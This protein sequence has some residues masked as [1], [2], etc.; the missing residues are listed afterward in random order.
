MDNINSNSLSLLIPKLYSFFANNMEILDKLDDAMTTNS[1]SININIEDSKGVI[2]SVTIPSFKWMKNNI[3]RLDKNLKTLTNYGGTGRSTIQLEDGTYRRVMLQNFPSEAKNIDALSTVSG[4]NVKSNWFFESLINPLMYVSFNLKNKVDETTDKVM[5]KRFILKINDND[6][7]VDWFEQN[8]LNS[9]NID[10][11]SFL[12]SIVRNDI[13]YVLD[14]DIVNLPPVEK[15]YDGQFYIT[16]I[17]NETYMDESKRNKVRKIYTLNKVTYNDVT[18]AFNNS[19]T[20]NTGDSLELVDADGNC[21]TRFT[22]D[23]INTS[24]QQVV[25]KLQEGSGSIS[26]G[27]VL[28][29]A[30][31]QTLN[32]K[33]SDI[34]LDINV[35][36]NEYNVVFVKPID[37]VSNIAATSW[38]KGT[39]F[40]TSKLTTVVNGNT[41]TLEDYYKKYAIDYGQMILDKMKDYFPTSMEG[42]TP[43][44]PILDERNFSIVHINKHLTESAEYQTILT[45]EANKETVKASIANKDTE[46]AL[47]RKEYNTTRD[48]G[49][50]NAITEVLN[51]L[52]NERNQLVA[53]YNGY[54][55][56]I[57]GIV[58]DY[59]LENVK[60]KYKLYGFWDMPE[61]M[62]GVSTGIQNII[63]FK[64]RYRYLSIDGNA[65]DTTTLTLYSNDGT[66]SS[67]VVSNWNYVETAVRRRSINPLTGEYEWDE[68]VTTD[69]DD[70]PINTIGLSI[71]K[72]E[73]IEIQVKSISE[74]GWPSN[75]LESEWSLPITVNYDPSME[76]ESL[77][78][79][80]ER[81]NV[82]MARVAL[83]RDL[84]S[85]RMYDHLSDSFVNG[86]N[87]FAHDAHSIASGFFSEENSGAP[88][89]LFTKLN[90]V[91]KDIDELKSEVFKTIGELAATLT[92]ERGE[93]VMD[94]TPNQNNLVDCGYYTD[95]A[96]TTEA[97]EIITKKFFINIRSSVDGTGLR[98]IS[99]LHGGRSI[100]ANE[101][102][103]SGC[104]DNVKESFSNYGS[105]NVSDSNYNTRLKYDH[106]P[107]VVNSPTDTK[108][109]THTSRPPMQSAQSCG[110]FVYARY[111]DIDG[112][113]LYTN[114][115]VN[116]NII[117]LENGFSING[118][119]FALRWG[120][121]LP[122]EAQNTNENSE[123]IISVFDDIL[124]DG[125]I[126]Y[127][128]VLKSDL[129]NSADS[130]RKNTCSFY[131]SSMNPVVKDL[132]TLISN[133][134]SMFNVTVRGIKTSPTGNNNVIMFN[135]D[136]SIKGYATSNA[137]NFD[138]TS[139][140]T[141][142]F[143]LYNLFTQ[144][145]SAL[146]EP[147]KMYSSVDANVMPFTA[148]MLPNISR[149][150]RVINQHDWRP[151][152]SYAPVSI[153]KPTKVMKEYVCVK[154]LYNTNTSLRQLGGSEFCIDPDAIVTLY[155]LSPYG[156]NYH[157]VYPYQYT[158]RYV[159]EHAQEFNGNFRIGVGAGNAVGIAND[160]LNVP[161][162]ELKNT[163]SIKYVEVDTEYGMD[164]IF[165][166]V[167]CSFTDNDKYNIG[168]CTCGS[169][170][171]LAPQERKDINLDSD[172]IS[173]Y[174]QIWYG[175][176]ESIK[177]PIVFQ[178]RMTDYLGNL[179]G[180][181]Q[182]QSNITE[183]PTYKRK[184]GIDF[185]L[186]D[187]DS[188]KYDLEFFA[189]YKPNG[190]NASNVPRLNI[191]EAMRDIS[192]SLRL[193]RK[194]KLTNISSE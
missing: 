46:I 189:K 71:N 140:Y 31:Y 120:S 190:T 102:S 50:R 79:I 150:N 3:E 90:N 36:F 186:S 137:Q 80:V 132:P 147:R 26:R 5:V 76:G 38:S 32:T 25:L 174:K 155:I 7:K 74:A 94:L 27:S 152:T 97:G 165:R 43:N 163:V 178:Y 128:W 53:E 171:Y 54:V 14:E 33:K 83:M 30:T 52:T 158:A 24:K 110:Q 21:S 98:L 117:T 169:Y 67:A 22:I 143:V 160:T 65:N 183:N 112:A 15:R 58:K 162:Y 68:V 166:T 156:Q 73:Q 181:K 106:V 75:P 154:N 81:N 182:L 82:D 35:G 84:E 16:D 175:D 176:K 119:E 127:R 47:R 125:T 124:Q 8:L 37:P 72:G 28:R 92:N 104:Y 89:T 85:L 144:A 11:M 194:T 193:N 129:D 118:S 107:I 57:Q 116:D 114:P 1:D 56:S 49:T 146:Y 12:T 6:T 141:K 170:L 133:F 172:D 184:I 108:R 17:I 167:R 9:D 113:P 148:G 173:A 168:K 34:K 23:T 192:D 111:T 164:S 105:Y 13:P 87:Y 153:Q 139:I 180:D 142:E 40:Y 86:D 78:Q 60:A 63:K 48:E 61:E 126:K 39:G 42:V 157:V 10:Y 151:Q 159:A 55:N 66:Q 161:Q 41:M 136:Y 51:T 69:V 103:K 188:V 77:T 19:C 64:V 187:N 123:N 145:I 109:D 45:S 122:A 29:L 115:K 95:N 88:I 62:R 93:V 99:R 20:L 96:N 4:F 44:A 100:M 191:T 2:K 135:S 70:N 121:E 131:I 138:M 101:S 134:A 149:I 179:N 177:I 185:W 91:S 59:N 18:A 130:S